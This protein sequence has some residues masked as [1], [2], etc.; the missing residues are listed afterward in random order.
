VA[1]RPVA[2]VDVKLKLSILML[3]VIIMAM[4]QI[5]LQ[6]VDNRPPAM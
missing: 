2:E 1:L 3:M 6:P 5:L 4:L